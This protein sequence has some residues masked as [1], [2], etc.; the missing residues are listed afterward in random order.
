MLPELHCKNYFLSGRLYNSTSMALPPVVV[1]FTAPR[2]RNLPPNPLSFFHWLQRDAVGN[3]LLRLGRSVVR[4]AKLLS[5]VV[6][7]A[8]WGLCGQR[9]AL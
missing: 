6:G 3:Q 8:G 5:D 2:N 4:P 9:G 7:M 1:A